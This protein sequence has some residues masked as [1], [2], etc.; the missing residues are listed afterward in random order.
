MPRRGIWTPAAGLRWGGLALLLTLPWFM[1]HGRAGVS[2]FLKLDNGKIAG[3][4]LNA[5]H[6][7][8]IELLSMGFGGSNSGTTHLGNFDGAGKSNVNDI[9]LFKYNDKSTPELIRR[10]MTGQPIGEAQIAFVESDLKT[11]ERPV[12][13]ISLNNIL[14]TSHTSG[15]SGGEDRLTEKFTLNFSEFTYQTFSYSSS[16]G[17]ETDSPSMTWNIAEN[18]GGTG[19]GNTAPSITVI[20]NQ[21]TAEDTP[22]TASF[23]LTDTETAAGAL[24]LSRSTNN[25]LVVPLSG[26]TFGGS[27]SSRTVIIHPAANASGSATVTVTVT[28]A[29]GLSASRSFTVTVNPVNDPPAIQAIENQ[30]TNQDTPL[31]VALNVSD[32]DTA[33]ANISITPVSGNPALIPANHITFSGSGASTQMTLTP[34]AGASGTALITLTAN[35]GALNSPPVSFTLTVNAAATGPT[36]IQLS[37]LAVDEQSPANTVV[38]SL[39]ASDPDDGGNVTFSLTDSAGGRFKLG[40]A[41]LSQ[42]LVDNGSLLDFETAASHAIT[43]RATDPDL[44][45][46]D[47]VFTISVTNV[48]EAPILTN[49]PVPNLTIDSTTPITGLGVSD[50]DSGISNITVT[51]QVSGGLLQLDSSGSLAGMVTGNSSNLVTVTAPV[52]D[53][54]ATLEAGGLTYSTHGLSPGVFA[55]T[56][57]ANDLGNTGSGGPQSSSVA[58][59]LTVIDTP[60]NHWRR[61]HF[62]AGQLANPAISGLLADAD[63]DGVG[64]LLEYGIGSDPLDSADGPGLVEFVEEVVEGVKFP[65]VRFNR[66]KPGSDPALQIQL[67][68]AT[69]DF[70]WRINPEDTV[71]VRST[72]LDAN[73]DTVVIRSTLPLGDHTRQ[74]MR[75]RFTMVP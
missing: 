63:K 58:V 40:G 21:V 27:G 22:V 24:T 49:S 42:V 75:L 53:I 65:A 57:Q 3:E 54:A 19:G 72:E 26:I 60:F 30:I 6:K 25:P 12:V 14:V 70:N 74:M 17:L 32:I 39:T 7:G 67:E 48:N 5:N 1:D 38:G 45:T 11:G 47:K 61:L 62:D 44:N 43:V 31:E 64:N 71:Q 16:T 59:D 29:G 34:V 50:P 68:I 46:F 4:S 37:P 9:T 52:A 55:L 51:F 20:A 2:I 69:D 8:E 33:A 23:T 15:G 73:R 10:V 18:T 56:I 35:D 66:L 41:G 28:D 36:D 13:T